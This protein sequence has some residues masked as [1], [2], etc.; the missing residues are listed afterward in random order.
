[1]T[2][3]GPSS[4]DPAGAFLRAAGL[5]VDRATGSRVVGHL[6]L[7]PDHHTPWGVVH[8]GVYATAI[9]SAASIGASAAV[10]EKGQVAVGLTN[11]S[12][13]LRSLTAG[14]GR[15]R[16]GPAPERGRRPARLNPPLNRRQVALV[17][18]CRRDGRTPPPAPPAR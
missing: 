5:V 16:R 4:I 2:A 3:T 17:G 8:G 15:P 14:P 18:A 9:E 10:A 13:F 12:H 11:T 6:E 7:G 1:M